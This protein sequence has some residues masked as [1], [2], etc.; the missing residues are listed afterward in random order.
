MLALSLSCVSNVPAEAESLELA[1]K[2]QQRQN[3]GEIQIDL[4]LS[5][6]GPLEQGGHRKLVRG[7]SPW[8]KQQKKL[9][10][11]NHERF[12]HGKLPQIRG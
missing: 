11:R 5:C 1:Q 3:S 6:Q 8:E 12:G 2:C 9:V 4:L 10:E 7:A